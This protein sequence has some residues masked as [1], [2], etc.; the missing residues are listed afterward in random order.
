[1]AAAPRVSDY[2]GHHVAPPSGLAYGSM[3]A[4]GGHTAAAQYAFPRAHGISNDAVD[5]FNGAHSQGAALIVGAHADPVDEYKRR[6]VLAAGSHLAAPERDL[7]RCR[8][9]S[10]PGARRF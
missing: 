8:A 9:R 7:D 5:A 4:P 3:A 2:A 6:L 10:P 1:M